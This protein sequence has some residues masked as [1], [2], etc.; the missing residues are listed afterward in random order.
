MSGPLVAWSEADQNEALFDPWTLVHAA[1]GL[2]AG[3]VGLPLGASTLAAVAYEVVESQLERTKTGRTFFDVS[4]PEAPGNQVV[5][6]L[7][8]ALGAWAGARYK[9]NL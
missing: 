9:G 4:G 2:A 5:D 6:V 8:F 7:V 1:A 3:L